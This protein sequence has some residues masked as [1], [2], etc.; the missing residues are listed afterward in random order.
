MEPGVATLQQDFQEPEGRQEVD[1]G[2][3]ELT[4][5]QHLYELRRRLFAMALAI[6]IGTGIG[7]FLA[8]RGIDFLERPAK[9]VYPNFAPSQI[10]P[11]EFVGAYFKVAL[12]IGLI[13]AMPILV[14]E[15]L[16]FVV[17]ALTR[18]ERR[19]MF[20]IL[21]GVFGLFL[22]GVVFSY[23]LVVPR[24][25]DFILNFGKG[26][27]DIHIRVGLYV[28]FVVRLVFWT[29]VLFELPIVMMVPAKF[30]IIRARK[31]LKW[32]RY[33]IV[34]GFLA[35]A[36]VIPNISPIEQISVAIPIIGLYFVGVGLAKLVQ[37]KQAAVSE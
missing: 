27:V 8:K 34:L 19:W 26:Q 10:E 18:K 11:L 13:I 17:P 33:A 22:S 31:Y 28:D 15:I 29:G 23:Y 3:Q 20:P 35:A 14:Y 6:A 24:A 32:W 37:P 16:A 12:L 5:M 7:L 1:E 2:G 30:G 4:I 21:F 9:S 25:L 36:A